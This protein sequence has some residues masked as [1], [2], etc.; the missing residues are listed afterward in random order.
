M[1]YAKFTR[2]EAGYTHDQEKCKKL[3]LEKDNEYEVSD[4][5]IGSFSSTISLV[6]F[7]NEYFNSVNF[8]YYEYYNGVLYTVD[9]YRRYRNDYERD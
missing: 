4:I 1:I 5:I 3:G 2:P 9:I 7:P 8:E 6:D